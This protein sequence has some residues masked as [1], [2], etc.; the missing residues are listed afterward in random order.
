VAVDH[1]HRRPGRA[2][3]SAWVRYHSEERLGKDVWAGQHRLAGRQLA[4]S[5]PA[6]AKHP[7]LVVVPARLLRDD[8]EREVRVVQQRWARHRNFR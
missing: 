6:P 3:V 2:E 4:A 1:L 8:E 7:P 5:P